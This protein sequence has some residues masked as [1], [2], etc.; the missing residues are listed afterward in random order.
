M[1]SIIFHS[2]LPNVFAAEP[3]LC[4]EV[5]LK[6]IELRRGEICLVEAESGTG[7]STMCSYLTG[8]RHDYSGEILFDRQD[9]N[10]YTHAKWAQIRCRHISLLFQELRLFPELTAMENVEIKNRLTGFLSRKR[11]EEMFDLLGIGEKRD[12]RTGK[13]SFGQ[14]QRVAMIRALAQPFDFILLDEPVS[15]LDDKNSQTM[16][17]LIAEEASRQGAGIISTSIGRHMPLPYN[18]VLKL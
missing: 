16:A 14:Q 17:T 13:M 6:D 4:S 12:V 3:K 7:K 11:I 2:V 5:W 9:I 10:S 8:F 18:R 15:H 1:E